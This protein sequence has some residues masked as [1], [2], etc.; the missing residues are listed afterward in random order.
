MKLL[1]SVAAP[2]QSPKGFA[3]DPP[4]RDGTAAA[5][6]GRAVRTVARRFEPHADRQIAGRDAP[7]ADGRGLRRPTRSRGRPSAATPPPRR[8]PPFRITR[9]R[10]V[11]GQRSPHAQESRVFAIISSDLLCLKTRF[12]PKP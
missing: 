5:A 9:R 1:R 12:P 4:D 8:E 7:V 6:A 11:D 2:F 3:R 10:R